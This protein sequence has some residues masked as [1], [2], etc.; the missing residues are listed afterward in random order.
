VRQESSPAANAVAEGNPSRTAQAANEG[1][2]A[3]AYDAYS[4]IAN[5]QV[6]KRNTKVALRGNPRG[7]SSNHVFQRAFGD[8]YCRHE[9]A[10]HAT[11]LFRAGS[12]DVQTAGAEEEEI[13]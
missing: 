6:E 3:T 7:V 4:E 2:Y 1:T 5:F 8:A 9:N 10:R 13:E 12:V 11:L